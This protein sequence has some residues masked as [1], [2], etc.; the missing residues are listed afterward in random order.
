MIDGDPGRG[1]VGCNSSR[2]PRSF[3]HERQ[4]KHPSLLPQLVKWDFVL[5]R[6]DDTVV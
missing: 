3:V 6:I 4:V 1:L 2:W 5:L